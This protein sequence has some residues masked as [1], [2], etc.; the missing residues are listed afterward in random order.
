MGVDGSYLD[1]GRIIAILSLV[2]SLIVG[3]LSAPARAEERPIAAA[4]EEFDFRWQLEGLSSW[5]AR[6]FRL[7][8]TSGDGRMT[9][10]PDLEGRLAVTFVA[11]S[12]KAGSN[13]Y[14]K[15]ET[16][17]DLETLRTL[18]VRDSLRF[19][20]KDRVKEY[21]LRELDVLD[22]LSGLQVMRYS[23]PTRPQSR[24]IWSSGKTYPVRVLL[25]P[26][27]SRTVF[28]QPT[29]VRKLSIRGER[30]P[31]QRYWSA[32]ADIWLT[33]DPRALPV[34]IFYKQSLGRLRLLLVE[35]ADID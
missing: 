16:Q 27:E 8:P 4:P 5:F 9:L 2:L 12:E 11:T 22:V 13:E 17:V 7:L 15:Y 26:T 6:L 31:G 35:P 23:A 3:T 10:A 21:D 28:G 33:D 20:R 29:P 34:E 14:W 30:V 24:S 18:H 32:Y 1:Q 19:G 25:G